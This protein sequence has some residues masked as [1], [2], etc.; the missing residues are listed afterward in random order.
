MRMA[1]EI[2]SLSNSIRSSIGFALIMA[3]RYDEAIAQL[4][5]GLELPSYRLMTRALIVCAPTRAFK[6]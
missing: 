3:R 1:A 5:K 2:N 4:K 6:T